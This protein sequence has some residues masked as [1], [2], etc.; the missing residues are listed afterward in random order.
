MIPVFTI[1]KSLGWLHSIKPLV[2]PAFFGNA[3]F[4]FLLRQFYRTIPRELSESAKLDGCSEL[5]IHWRIM[6]PL[7]KP[8]LAMVA[9]FTFIWSWNDFVN[10]LIYLNDDA[11]YT[12]SVGLQ[13]F[14]SL[15]G[16]EW[17]LLMAAS[18]VMTLPIIVLFFFTQKTFIEGIVF[19]GIKG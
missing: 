17:S 5:D 14:L 12:L 13:Q 15:H 1:F 19:T 10:P 2:V 6:L 8:A 7:A 11:K 16:A 4:I 18:T 9:L 3:F